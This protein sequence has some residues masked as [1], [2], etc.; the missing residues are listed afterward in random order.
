[1]TERSRLTEVFVTLA[2][3]L[4][5]NYDAVDL[6]QY[7]VDCTVDLVEV[8]AAGIL[9]VDD[10]GLQVAAVST[11]EISALEFFELQIDEGPC[12]DCVR[13]GEAVV[14]VTAADAARRWPGFARVADQVGMRSTHAVPLRLRGEVIGAMNVYTRAAER[15][16]PEELALA[17][18]LAD[19]ATIGILQ[20]RA[21][22]EQTLLAEQLQH[23][24][25]SRVVVEQAKGM[26]AARLDVT[27]EEAFGRMRT[28][29]R[30]HGIRLVEVAHGVLDRSLAFD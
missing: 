14:N 10:H 2:D 13:S 23:A 3:T 19:M 29:A 17:Q 18:A 24:L 15:L 4:V 8:D 22:A 30:S 27:T 26:L 28:H 11:E 12:I 16:E 5:E 6:M 21:I 9:L 25:Q 7:L 20:Q 1:M